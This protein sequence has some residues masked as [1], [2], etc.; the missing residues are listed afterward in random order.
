MVY[1]GKYHSDWWFKGVLLFEETLISSYQWEI[2]CCKMCCHPLTIRY[3]SYTL[4]AGPRNAREWSEVAQRQS[5]CPGCAGPAIRTSKICGTSSANRMSG[6][7]NVTSCDFDLQTGVQPCK[8]SQPQEVMEE[9]PWTF[10]DFPKLLGD[11]TLQ[12]LGHDNSTTTSAG[13]AWLG[14][15]VRPFLMA[16]NRG[17]WKLY[18]FRFLHK[19][20]DFMKLGVSKSWI[21]FA[22]LYGS[23][24]LIPPKTFFLAL[25][26]STYVA[27]E[28]SDQTPMVYRSP[29]TTPLSGG[30]SHSELPLVPDDPRHPKYWISSC[31]DG[32]WN[33]EMVR[34]SPWYSHSVSCHDVWW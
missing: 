26:K 7:Q 19:P 24:L 17:N 27:Q 1:K 21:N 34:I 30:C 22:M 29:T 13:R 5:S 2:D 6:F 31:G 4:V 15:F 3:L 28:G 12:G 32:I 8:Q 25:G 16:Q 11:F 23:K 9:F 33:R 10:D 14:G 18:I 20:W